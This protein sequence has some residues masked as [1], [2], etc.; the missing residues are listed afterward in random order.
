MAHFS[1]GGVK[2]LVSLLGELSVCTFFGPNRGALEE[3]SLFACFEQLQGAGA[4]RRGNLVVARTIPITGPAL[5][6][7]RER[8]QMLA[9]VTALP[10]MFRVPAARSGAGCSE[11]GG[12]IRAIRSSTAPPPNPSFERTPQKQAALHSFA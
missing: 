8:R 10:P 12:I 3:P 2:T 7:R 5:A 4:C 1:L 6:L 9:R 11:V